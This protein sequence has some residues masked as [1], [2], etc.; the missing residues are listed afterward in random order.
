MLSWETPGNLDCIAATE[1]SAVAAVT[2]P[3]VVGIFALILSYYPNWKLRF[4]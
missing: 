2:S 3:G 1:V 4:W